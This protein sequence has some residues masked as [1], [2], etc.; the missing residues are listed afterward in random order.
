MVTCGTFSAGHHLFAAALCAPI[1]DK[2]HAI[3]L[4]CMNLRVQLIDLT[5][6]LV[7]NEP[8]VTTTVTKR[9]KRTDR[10]DV[11]GCPNWQIS[12]DGSLYYQRRKATP[13][14][15]VPVIDLGPAAFPPVVPAH[16]DGS[17][18][19]FVDEL[20]CWHF[21]RRLSISQQR[22]A[23]TI[24]L[25]GDWSNC[26]ADN[27]RQVLDTE[28]QWEQKMRGWMAS[29]IPAKRLKT[30]GAAS[31]GGRRNEVA[32][33]DL[34]EGGVIAALPEW[35]DVV[36]IWVRDRLKTEQEKACA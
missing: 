34:R 16:G 17:R 25:D 30:P 6:R 36:P 29:N 31:F 7:E 18:E 23:Y 1:C 21:H 20:V 24:H 13:D 3:G 19:R 2:S 12:P 33:S 32:P 4:N 15:T 9:Q 14:G 27:V 10:I 28:W 11:Q 22:F 5:Y 26:A 8:H 35:A